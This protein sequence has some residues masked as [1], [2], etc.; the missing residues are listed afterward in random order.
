M[1]TD[2]VTTS[3]EESQYRLLVDTAKADAAPE[4]ARIRE[5]YIASRAEK[6]VSDHGIT[7]EQ[8]R[9]IAQNRIS[10]AVLDPADIITFQQ[11]GAVSVAAILADPA[12]YHGQ[13]CADPVE[14]EEGLSKA[15]VFVNPDG[16]IIINSYLHGGQRYYIRK[17]PR[18][19]ANQ[20]TKTFGLAVDI[21][22]NMEPPL[23]PVSLIPDVI[24]EYARDQAELMGVDPGVICLTSLAALAGC[25]DDRI[26]IQPKRHDTTWRESGRLWVAIIGDPSTM[27]SPGIGK[28]LSPVLSIARQWRE[29]HQEAMREWEDECEGIKAAEKKAKLP[30]A[31]NLK[32]LTVSDVTVEK[33]GDI[34]SKQE[35]RGILVIRDELTGWLMGMDAYKNGTGTD[36]AA[37]LETFNGGPHEVDRIGRGSLCV[38]N[39]SASVVGGIQ[40]Q[41]ID[42]YAKVTNHDGMLQR[43]ILYRARNAT[44]GV[45]RTP[46]MAAEERYT[47]LME[48][49]AAMQ[50]CPEV[51]ELSEEAHKI[52]EVFDEKLTRAIQSMPNKHLTAALGKWK[53]TFARLLL[54]FHVAEM[55]KTEYPTRIKVS[56]GTA[57]RVA[58]LLWRF[59][60]PQAI[61]FYEGMDPTQTHA[62]QLASL[63]LAREWERFTVKRDLSQNWSVYRTMTERDREEM[64]DRLEAYGWILPEDG[65]KLSARGKPTVYKVNPEV[66]ARFKAEADKER[67]R[68]EAV[69]AIMKEIK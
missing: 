16:S 8:A 20:D 60:L 17:A 57:Q 6:L 37:W 36:R 59:L 62:K 9:A 35:P 12:Q 63:I 11:R 2:F 54:V 66:H 68:R 51:V 44:R 41:V 46:N 27:K 52:R 15:K 65:S 61:A 56:K 53:G 5:T 31:P 43:F 50:P 69:V 24:G 47:E 10:G 18:K 28:A 42:S 30:T 34:L 39:W 25:L 67:K 3:H 48:H 23:F 22:G 13:T 64:L 26:Q 19:T 45:D 55:G 1:N 29:K 33:L 49:V 7:P 40:P 58:L 21:F 14:P 32:R 38:E 4:A